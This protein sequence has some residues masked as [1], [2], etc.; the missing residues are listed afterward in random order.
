[1]KVANNF[2]SIFSILSA[3]DSEGSELQQIQ[4]GTIAMKDMTIQQMTTSKQTS[5][6]Y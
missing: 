4:V 3:C 6:K 1:M 2:A 5:V